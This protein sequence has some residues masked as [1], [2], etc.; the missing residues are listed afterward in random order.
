MS[1]DTK[2]IVEIEDELDKLGDLE[3]G[4]EKYCKAIDGIT[5]LYGKAI[6]D[7]KVDID[8]EAQA[9]ARESERTLKEQQMR[10]DRKDRIVK[11]IIG[12]ASV[13]LPLVVTIWGT[14]VSLKFEETGTITTHS[15]RNFVQRLFRK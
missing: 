15:G 7:R 9:A 8:C 2:L 12:A 11:N 10:E 6:E 5:K 3:F 14:T 4:S 13:V 1:I